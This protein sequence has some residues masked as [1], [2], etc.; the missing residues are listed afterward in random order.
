[1][2]K[3]YSTELLTFILL[4]FQAH[5]VILAACSPLF[6][7]ILGHNQ[8]QLNPFLYLKG[9]NQASSW[10]FKSVALKLDVI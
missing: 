2:T 1:M 6:R 8:N 9:I 7:R 5:K 3:M 4:L 10:N